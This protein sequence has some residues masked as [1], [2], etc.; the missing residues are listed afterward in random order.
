MVARALLQICFSSQRCRV[1]HEYLPSPHH[2]PSY[3]CTSPTA[4]VSLNERIVSHDSLSYK[5]V[6]RSRML[7][8][9]MPILKQVAT[10]PLNKVRFKSFA[11]L[12]PCCCSPLL[13]SIVIL[14]CENQRALKTM[15]WSC[16]LYFLACSVTLSKAQGTDEGCSMC[17]LGK[18]FEAGF[19]NW[20]L[21]SAA[22][23][24]QFLVP[25]SSPA[26]DAISETPDKQRMNHNPGI[27]NEPDIER[28][29]IVSTDDKK[30]D[31]NGD[32]VSVI[33]ASMTDLV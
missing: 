17:A 10:A 25:D 7:L 24:L 21:P 19:E 33:P 3:V 30:C 5:V 23:A 28:E 1:F 18:L 16:Y 9:S 11:Q 14:H 6:T 2:T 29:T 13:S 8:K 4:A 31:R 20:I 27:V 26:P 32:G 22:G 15:K 12:I